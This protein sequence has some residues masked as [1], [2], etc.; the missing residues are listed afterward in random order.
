MLSLHYYGDLLT[1]TLL[2]IIFHNPMVKDSLKFYFK[3][4][5]YYNQQLYHHLY[6]R[7]D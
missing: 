1:N 7:V 6:E 2:C 4:E 3:L 5:F